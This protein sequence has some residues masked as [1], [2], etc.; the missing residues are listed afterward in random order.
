M[1]NLQPPHDPIDALGEAYE[2]LLEATI[3]DLHKARERSGP[4]LH[5]LI[6]QTK[7]KLLEAEEYTE[8]DLERVGQYLKRDLID[9]ASYLAE[10]GEEFATW[11]GFDVQLIEERLKEQFSQAADQTTVELLKLKEQAALS[12]YRSGEI[13]GPGTLVCD[14]CG[15]RLQFHRV[16]KIPPCPRCKGST[17][18]RQLN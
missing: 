2:R 9:A 17:F 7:I 5:A 1:K 15:E 6:D 18:H 13:T 11:L 4:A 8:E 10:S 14:Q 12:A 16:S 3:D